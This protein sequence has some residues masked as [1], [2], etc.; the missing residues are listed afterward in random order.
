MKREFACAG[1]FSS[2]SILYHSKFF[3]K[4][5]PAYDMKSKNFASGSKDPEFLGLIFLLLESNFVYKKR[6]SGLNLFL[7]VPIGSLIR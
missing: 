6:N 1:L 5:N 2:A 3:K 7:Q 4:N